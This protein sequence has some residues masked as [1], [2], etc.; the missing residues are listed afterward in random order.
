MPK[1]RFTY[2]G[3]IEECPCCSRSVN[4]NLKTLGDGSIRKE[5]ICSSCSYHHA[6]YLL[7]FSPKQHEDTVLEDIDRSNQESAWEKR[8][9]RITLE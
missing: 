7:P 3:P 8:V 6:D 2:K 9:K 4:V 5:T 1:S